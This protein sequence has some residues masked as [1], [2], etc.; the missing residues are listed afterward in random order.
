MTREKYSKLH[1]AISNLSNA[2]AVFKGTKAEHDQLALDKK[3][4]LE[5]LVSLAEEDAKKEELVFKAA[6]QTNCT[7]EATMTQ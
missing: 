7:T 3:L 5:L 2:A 6:N 1:T 4:L